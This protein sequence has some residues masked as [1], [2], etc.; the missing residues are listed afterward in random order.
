MN[1]ENSLDKLQTPLADHELNQLADTITN[2]VADTKNRLAQTVNTTLVAIT[3][4]LVNILLSLSKRVILKLNTEQLY[5]HHWL[6]SCVL[7][8]EKDTVVLISTICESFICFIQF[9]RRCLTN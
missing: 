7:N 3:G 5:S 1:N 2:L 6:K 9:V 8:W 4:I